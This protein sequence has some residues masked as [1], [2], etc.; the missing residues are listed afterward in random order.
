MNWVDLII[1]LVVGFFIWDGFHRG[2]LKLGWELIGLI[3]AFLL[4]L[5]FYL[6][7][8]NWLTVL[9]LSAILAKPVVFLAIWV[10]TQI[11]FYFIGKLIDFYTPVPWKESKINDYAGIVPGALKGVIFIAVVLVFLIIMPISNSAKNII[12][13]SYFSSLLIQETANVENQIE[14]IFNGQTSLMTLT[15]IPVNEDSTSAL[16]FSTTNIRIDEEGEK[17]ILED[18]NKERAKVGLGALESDILV[19]NVARAHSRDMLLKGYFSHNSPDGQTVFDRL[20]LANVNF[21]E[22]AENIALAPTTALAHIGLINSPKHKANILD[23]D[24]S[25]VGIGV[26]DAGPYGLMVTQDFV[27]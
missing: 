3:L 1:I 5:R 22:V 19:R 14:Q 7:V 12:N 23:P 13:H 21:Q 2:F 27:K 26:I 4:G 20:T 18:I 11:L 10:L 15:N 24:F 25:R 6:P 8:A 17:A 9:H 16:N